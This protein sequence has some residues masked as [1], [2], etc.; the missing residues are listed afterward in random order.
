TNTLVLFIGYGLAD[1]NFRVLLQGLSRF[2]EKGLGRQHIAVMLPP[3]KGNSE[4]EK[5]KIQK[6]LTAYYQNIDVKVFWGTVQE[7]CDEL[8]RRWNRSVQERIRNSN[9]SLATGRKRRSN[10]PRKGRS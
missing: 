9:K 3:G 2:M 7:F 10:S 6:Y 8:G 4:V 1:W 5:Q